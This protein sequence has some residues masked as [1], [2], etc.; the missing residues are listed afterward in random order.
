MGLTAHVSFWLTD[1]RTDRQTDAEP[2][3]RKPVTCP[4]GFGT[5][6]IWA[7]RE[8][9]PSD[10]PPASF[11]SRH[12]QTA[13]TL[14]YCQSGVTFTTWMF[15]SSPLIP[16]QAGPGLRCG[17]LA[18]KVH[19]GRGAAIPAYAQCGWDRT[20]LS[21]IEVHLQSALQKLCFSSSVCPDCSFPLLAHIGR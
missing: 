2:C 13:G 11:H 12:R 17:F 5:E 4:A 14:A 20:G 21:G 9:S 10:C 16:S 15:T 18:E 8:F 6:R 19:A 1:R 7:E 3:D